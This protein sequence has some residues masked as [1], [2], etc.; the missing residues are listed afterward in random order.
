MHGEANTITKYQ[1]SNK[2]T[3]TSQTQNVISR[4]SWSQQ[5]TK[6]LYQMT[7]NLQKQQSV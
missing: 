7:A 3:Q 1:K 4:A 5:N 6:K 2:N